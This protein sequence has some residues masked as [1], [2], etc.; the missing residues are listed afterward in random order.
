MGLLCKSILS[1]FLGNSS[2]ER[3]QFL[4]SPSGNTAHSLLLSPLLRA[5]GDP[6]SSFSEIL[7][8]LK[9]FKILIRLSP[10]TLFPENLGLY[11]TKPEILIGNFCL[12]F[13]VD[14]VVSS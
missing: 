5:Q 9:F 6:P 11:K 13:L 12:Q 14:V 4:V 2:S 10:A 7:F 3:S 8:P 1:H